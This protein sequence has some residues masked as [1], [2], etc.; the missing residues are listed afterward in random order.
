MVEKSSQLV[1]LVITDLPEVLGLRKK[2]DIPVVCLAKAEDAVPEGTHVI[3][4]PRG[5]GLHL[6]GT[7]EE[8]ELFTSFF[9]GLDIDLAEPFIRIRDAVQETRKSTTRTTSAA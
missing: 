8:A 4:G 3:T 1:D 6:A 5:V 2:L 7:S 9:E